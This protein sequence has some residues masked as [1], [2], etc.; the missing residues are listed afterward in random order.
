MDQI[1][2]FADRRDEI[3]R[4]QQRFERAS[5]AAEGTFTGTDATGTVTVV[6]TPT[7]H[8]VEVRVPVT[9]RDELAPEGLAPAVMDA[10]TEA[11]MARMAQWG[12]A[13]ADELDAPAP[14]TRPLPPAYES[15][16]GR[17]DEYVT[18]HAS[19]E[20]AQA[21]TD[22]FAEFLR[23]VLASIDEAKA[24]VARA[25]SAE[26]VGTSEAGHV[27]VVVNGTGD[28]VGVRYD[29]GWLERAHPANIGR[30]TVQAQAAALRAAGGRTPASVVAGTRL[31]ELERLANDPEA[32]ARRLRMTR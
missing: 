1:E 26:I 11:A 29:E 25:Q 16:A 14:A 24:E 12:E 32:L 2:A 21:T 18:R 17:I 27:R 19:P 30:E 6:V 15:L 10:R 8:F 20:E 4:M 28:V 13:V 9:W 22:A 31:G 3:D 5:G 7:G 23:E